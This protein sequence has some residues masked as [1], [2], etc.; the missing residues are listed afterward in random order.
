MGVVAFSPLSPLVARVELEGPAHVI[1][2]TSDPQQIHRFGDP[3]APLYSLQQ[4]FAPDEGWQITP[5]HTG[6]YL[7]EQSVAGPALMR[8]LQEW[9]RGEHLPRGSGLITLLPAGHYLLVRSQLPPTPTNLIYFGNE[10]IPAA[11]HMAQLVNGKEP[12]YGIV[13]SSPA[14]TTPCFD[15]FFLGVVVL[16]VTGISWAEVEK[17]P[18]QHS[19]FFFSCLS[20]VQEHSP[21]HD[22]VLVVPESGNLMIDNLRLYST[23]TVTGRSVAVTPDRRLLDPW[24]DFFL[25]SFVSTVTGGQEKWAGSHLGLLPGAPT[26]PDMPD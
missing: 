2:D 10:A 3:F 12:V 9:T 18:H 15:Q 7:D 26:D 8:S 21:M 16:H 24:K 23:N 11:P 1:L 25:P 5:S 14:D 13:V 17:H 4:P 20:P 19:V 22:Y 6:R